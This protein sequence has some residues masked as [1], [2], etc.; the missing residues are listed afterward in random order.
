MM[1]S[2]WFSHLVCSFFGRSAC[3][4]D[5]CINRSYLCNACEAA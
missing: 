5:I 3:T 4:C 2:E 1:K